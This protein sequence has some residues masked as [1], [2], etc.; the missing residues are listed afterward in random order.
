MPDTSD[1]PQRCS[2]PKCRKY[3]DNDYAFKQ[4]GTCLSTERKRKAKKRA[5]KLTEPVSSVSTSSRADRDDCEERSRVSPG[6]PPSSATSATPTTASTILRS[7]KGIVPP[8]PPP[9]PPQ[10]STLLSTPLPEPTYEDH[11]IPNVSMTYQNPQA[12]FEALVLF[13]ANNETTFTGGYAADFDPLISHRQHVAA[14]SLWVWRATKWRFRVHSHQPTDN[15]HKTSY[16]C[17]QDSYHMQKEHR[18]ALPNAK[19]RDCAGMDRFPCDARLNISSNTRKGKIAVHIHIRHH[20]NHRAYFDINM[21]K[22]ATALIRNNL[23]LT[24]QALANLVRGSFG[25]MTPLQ[26]HAAWRRFS[27]GIWKRDDD[28]VKSAELLLQ[29][30]GEE[31]DHFR[32]PV[33]EGVTMV[34]FGVKRILTKLRGR[35]VEIAA[36]ATFNT[37]ASGL[38]LYSIMAEQD[39]A[40]FPLSYCFLTTASA[41][42]P[43][44]RKNALTLWAIALRDRYGINPRFSHLDK[45]MAEIGMAKSAWPD[46]KI[47]LCQYHFGD[48]VKSRTKKAKLATMPYNSDRAHAEFDFINPSFK[49]LGNADTSEYEGGAHENASTPQ[50]APKRRKQKVQPPPPTQRDRPWASQTTIR[51][52]PLSQQ[53]VVQPYESNSDESSDDDDDEPSDDDEGGGQGRRTFCPEIHQDDV[54]EMMQAAFCAHPFLPGEAAPNSDAIHEWAVRRMYQYCEENDLPELW[55]Y[56][57]ENWL[58]PT[59]WELWAR[60]AQVTE[61]CLLKTTMIM[62]SHW[63]RIKV[64]FLC[65]YHSPRLDFF[66]HILVKKLLPHYYEKLTVL[67]HPTGRYRE[68]SSWRDDFKAKWKQLALRKIT[69]PLNDKY[70]PDVNQWTCTCP[71][72]ARSRFLICKHL[73]QGVRDLPVKF[74]WTVQRRRTLPFYKH[75]DLI[76]LDGRPVGT[77]VEDKE[78]LLTDVPRVELAL[79]FA[80]NEEDSA[81]SR[82]KEACQQHMQQR[83][84]EMEKF[85]PILRHQVQFGDER[86]LESIEREGGSMFR[87][88]E[89]VQDFQRRVDSTRVQGPRTWEAGASKTMFWKPMPTAGDG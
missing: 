13:T 2:R 12:L 53:I 7:P 6:D 59:R 16:W 54:L 37:N 50:K 32:I 63:R 35:V 64:D 29:E 22:E 51:I 84:A 39:G 10:R 75:A 11:P 42:S 81:W 34:A 55:A 61:L 4:C 19:P 28:P 89:Q 83:I 68:R 43:G 82:G 44:K 71:V 26:I 40:G 87:F 15:G 38:E 52:P 65:H 20:E 74:F 30:F 21:P 58:R 60:S 41:I 70:R 72:M 76:A 14:I 69:L 86:V 49:P 66:I 85:L 88:M 3:L 57:W 33:E 36:D 23:D 31:V 67:L 47:Q 25:N 1:T 73:V 18:S 24:P 17:C 62:E 46:S 27:E 48:A 56:L 77:D 9:L 79:E 8:P 45:D 80:M 5:A 78:V